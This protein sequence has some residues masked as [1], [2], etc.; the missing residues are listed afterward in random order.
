MASICHYFFFFQTFLA[1]SVHRSNAA[2][3]P[4]PSVVHFEIFALLTFIVVHVVVA[5]AFQLSVT[6]QSVPAIGAFALPHVVTVHSALTVGRTAVWAALES[7]VFAVPAGH[8]QARAILALAVFVAPVIAQLHVAVLTRPAGV[9]GASVAHAMAVRAA[10]QIAKL[11]ETINDTVKYKTM[12][13]STYILYI[14]VYP[15]RF[16][17]ISRQLVLV[18]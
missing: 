14:H 13:V 2:P 16:S 8:A 1:K 12:F 6:V 17:K 11:C 5:I 7:A 15:S 18:L 4:L 9:T 10:I 3:P